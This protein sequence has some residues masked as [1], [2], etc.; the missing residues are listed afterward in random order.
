MNNMMSDASIR[1]RTLD[2]IQK[3]V[4]QYDK[5]IFLAMKKTINFHTSEIQKL[6]Q[7]IVEHQRKLKENVDKERNFKKLSEMARNPE[8]KPQVGVGMQHPSI[9]P[10]NDTPV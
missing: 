6:Q 7:K 9:Y 8:D 5:E 4:L 1:Q 3:I 10:F 2:F